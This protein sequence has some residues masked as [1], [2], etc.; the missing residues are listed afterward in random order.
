MST[1]YNVAFTEWLIKISGVMVDMM[2]ENARMIC[3]GFVDFI[4]G[5]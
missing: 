3:Y 2:S 4:G 1:L 5:L